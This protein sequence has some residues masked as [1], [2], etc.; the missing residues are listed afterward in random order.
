MDHCIVNGFHPSISPITYIKTQIC[1]SDQPTAGYRAVL[2]LFTFMSG[3]L[4]G[5]NVSV[6]TYLSSSCISNTKPQNYLTQPYA[7][8]R[9]RTVLSFV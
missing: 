8:Y 3:K 2:L 5:T 4:I 9:Y 6:K 7:D 1:M